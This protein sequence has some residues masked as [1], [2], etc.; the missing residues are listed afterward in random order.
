MD[1]IK[2]AK[3]FTNSMSIG[4]TIIFE[5]GKK[6]NGKPL[7]RLRACS[8]VPQISDSQTNMFVLDGFPIAIAV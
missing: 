4:D 1:K 3:Y 6:T 8:A 5:L 7:S 2:G